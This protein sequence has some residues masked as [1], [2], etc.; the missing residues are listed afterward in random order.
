MPDIPHK[1]D[2]RPSKLSVTMIQNNLMILAVLPIIIDL[3]LNLNMVQN[4]EFYFL[5]CVQAPLDTGEV[6]SLFVIMLNLE[7]RWEACNTTEPSTPRLISAQTNNLFIVLSLCGRKP[8]FFLHTHANTLR[9]IHQLQ[10][11][12]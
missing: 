12:T 11:K 8:R 10:D 6:L 3:L 9:L 4:E 7:G 5:R 2:E 1:I